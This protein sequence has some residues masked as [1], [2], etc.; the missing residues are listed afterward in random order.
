MGANKSKE[1]I[2][3]KEE[4]EEKKAAKNVEFKGMR[5]F[6]D[7]PMPSDKEKVSRTF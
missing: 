3:K 1:K 7:E 4:Q 6:E 2:A 5:K